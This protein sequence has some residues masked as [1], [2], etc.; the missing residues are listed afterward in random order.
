VCRETLVYSIRFLKVY[1]AR[2]LRGG[3]KSFT[4]EQLQIEKLNL[5]SEKLKLRIV[6]MK[7]Q[8]NPKYL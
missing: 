1:I 5:Q 8:I 2:E 6:H 3:G 7:L 4:N